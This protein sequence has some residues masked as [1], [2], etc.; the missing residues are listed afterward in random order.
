MCLR[1]VPNARA[2]RRRHRVII[3][4]TSVTTQPLAKDR[5]QAIYA[6]PD[7]EVIGTLLPDSLSRRLETE[8]ALARIAEV[9]G[10][11]PVAIDPGHSDD[12]DAKVLWA[13]LGDHPFREWQFL[14]TVRHLAEGGQINDAFHTDIAIL[15]DDRVVNGGLKPSGFIHHISRCGST[16]A[17]KALARAPQHVVI[18]Q[19]GPLQ[20]GFWAY[21]TD[22]WR[23][24]LEATPAALRMF[25]NLIEAMTR[26]RR[27]G[28]AVAFVKSISWNVLYAEFFA[29]AYP[30]VPALFLY[31]DPVEVIASVMNETTAVLHA[32]GSREA[33]F[34][35]GRAVADT[36]EMSD[37]EYLAACYARYFQTVVSSKLPN[38]TWLNYTD[39]KPDR[40]ADIVARGLSFKPPAEIVDTMLAQFQFHSKDDSDSAK[41]KGDSEEKRK[42]MCE[43]DKAIIRS[44]CG[45]Y[46]EDL[47]R[48]PRNLFPK[49]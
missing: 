24:P 29:A 31:R 6:L 23:K 32:K 40:F 13:D 20:R 27:P 30:D 12:K 14:F 34:L 10:L 4:G 26:P 46:L 44:I 35:T 17:A 16:L 48:A 8:E 41:F 38:L 45:A 21:L 7:H 47:D 2:P 22:D 28:Q 19:G 39:L 43:A 15:A 33:E 36:A 25:R 18:T 37:V 11:V 3:R 49:A 42:A 9:P 5:L 1:R